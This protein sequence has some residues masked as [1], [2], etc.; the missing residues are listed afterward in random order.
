MDKNKKQSNPFFKSTSLT[1]ELT[2]QILDK[3]QLEKLRRKKA[4]VTIQDQDLMEKAILESFRIHRPITL[5]IQLQTGETAEITGVVTGINQVLG[6]IR[7][8]HLNG[9]EWI[10]KDKITG[11]KIEFTS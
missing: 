11:I 9:M 5:L 2:K 6:R 8:L 10:P 4:L 3:L 1:P 7:L